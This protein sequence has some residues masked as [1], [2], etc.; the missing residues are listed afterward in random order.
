MLNP[1]STFNCNLPAIKV[2]VKTTQALTGKPRIS[3][4][5]F[6]LLSTCDCTATIF[7]SDY[8]QSDF[9]LELETIFIISSTIAQTTTLIIFDSISLVC[10]DGNG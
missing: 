8:M 4:A 2:I 7:D 3:L 5:L 10:G 6:G 1:D 9:T